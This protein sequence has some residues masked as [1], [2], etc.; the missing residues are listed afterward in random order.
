MIPSHPTADLNSIYGIRYALTSYFEYRIKGTDAYL[1]KLNKERDATIERF[2]EVT[3]FN[4]TQLLLEKYGA[5]PKQKEQVPSA[6]REDK[7]QGP[8]KQAQAP[9]PRTGMAPPPTANIQR[10]PTQQLPPSTPERQQT[11]L[12]SAQASHQLAPPQDSPGAEFAPNAFGAADL[13]K[14]FSAIPA[15][16]FTQVHWYDKILDVLLG[17][18]ETQPKNRFVLICAECRLVN[19]QAPPGAR[20]LEDVGRWRC[21]GCHAWNGKEKKQEND[22]IGLVKGWEAER[23]MKEKDRKKS[24]TS[25]MSEGGID[26]DNRETEDDGVV[27]VGAEEG[28]DFDGAA[29][30]EEEPKPLSRNTRSKSKARG[31]K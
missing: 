22:V 7:I 24:A 6:G 21:G 12:S 1:K 9:G 11:N 29:E 18:D 20:T 15:T 31:K 3:K 19:G 23:Q 2:K 26:S 14:Q 4:S 17:E 10:A 5:S 30:S 13:S 25:G 8:Q 27:M 28:R 16:T